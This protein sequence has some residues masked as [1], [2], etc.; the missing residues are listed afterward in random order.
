MDAFLLGDTEHLPS[1]AGITGS[2][3]S[4]APDRSIVPLNHSDPVEGC[5]RV[6]H[7]GTLKWILARDM[8][9]SC[10]SLLKNYVPL[11]CYCYL[12]SKVGIDY[13][14]DVPDTSKSKILI[15]SGCV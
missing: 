7:Q 3:H 14:L 15:W 11:H 6:W 13:Y 1:A 2:Q 9:P 8:H 4:P 5:P 10:Q 12:F